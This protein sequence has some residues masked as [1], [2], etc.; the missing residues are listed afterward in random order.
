[1]TEKTDDPYS[2]F[3]AMDFETADNG[4]DSACS[5]GVVKVE[6]LSITSSAHWYIR[7]P[8][9]DFLFSWLHGITWEKVKNEPDF[10][11]IWPE[12]A[13]FCSGAS[14]I[15]AH[16]APFDRGVLEACCSA[17]GLPRPEWPFRCTVRAARNVLCISPAKLD[18]VCRELS[19]ELKH[20]DALSDA[21]ACARIMIEAIK[22]T[23]GGGALR[24][25]YT[26]C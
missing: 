10:A 24:S 7:P 20:H 22:K 1:M 23:A 21:S 4:R 14:F 26:N 3:V 15:A 8:R 2:C 12:L 5:V 9:R 18:N 19:I 17:A 25:A 11:G 13:E 6:N 16:N